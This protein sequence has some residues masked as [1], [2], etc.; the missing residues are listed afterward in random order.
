MMKRSVFLLTAIAGAMIVFFTNDAFF[1]WAFA[2]H[3]NTASWVARPALIIPFCLA[4]Y[5][6]RLDGILFCV[7]AIL[8]S[9]F[10]FPVPQKTD[11]RVIEF[12]AMEKEI[13]KAGFSLYTLASILGIVG[14][15]VAL[16]AAFWRRSLMLGVMIAAAGAGSKAL[17]SIVFS[18]ETGAVV[19]PYAGGGVAILALVI[20]LLVLYKRRLARGA[21]RFF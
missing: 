11:P 12:L 13:L 3:Q 4:A 10:W 20:L 19:L 1:E 16:A 15:L 14:F 21:G 8:T 2:R 7:L 18:P 17:W 5:F 9:M 6:R